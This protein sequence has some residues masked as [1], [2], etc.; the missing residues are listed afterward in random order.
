MNKKLRWALIALLAAALAGILGY[1]AYRDADRAAGVRTYTE[2]AELAGV[3]DLTALLPTPGPTQA[4]TPE[5]TPA[6][7]TAPGESAPSEEPVPTET[8]QT[9]PAEDTIPVF[10]ALENVDLAALRARNPEVLGWIAIPGVLSY[11]LMRGQDNSFYLS[12]TW[13]GARNSVGSVFMDY[14]CSAGMDDFNTVIY[15]HRTRR[16]AMF[17]SL[18]QYAAQSFWTAHPDVY[19]VTDAGV[20]RYRIYA[21]YEAELTGPAYY[22]HVSTEEG[23]EEFIRSGV[24]QS[25]ISADV[26]PDPGDRFITLSTCTG[27]SHSTRWVVQAF[28][29]EG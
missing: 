6:M 5:P 20:S 24:D 9:K 8:P 27:N 7:A 10:D 18:A 12:H 11:P 25:G 17:G 4:P 21:A 29:A 13:N 26:R 14:R 16:G 28:L 22:N 15:A 2:A 3:P 23:R 1:I 19:L